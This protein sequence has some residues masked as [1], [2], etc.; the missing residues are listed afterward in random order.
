MR[1]LEYY[2]E[3]DYDEWIAEQSPIK[4]IRYGVS[5]D[6]KLVLTQSAVKRVD[7]IGNF[8]YS[9]KKRTKMDIII[10]EESIT[11]ESGI[12]STRDTTIYSEH[13]ENLF[14]HKYDSW[15]EDDEYI[16]LLEY[17]HVKVTDN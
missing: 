2:D 1:L 8:Y 7:D 16:T 12:V 6:G 5:K 9:I 10:V 14:Q 3:E 17:G 13:R 4:S 11:F 15:A